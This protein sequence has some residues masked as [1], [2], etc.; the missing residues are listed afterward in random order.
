VDLKLTRQ[1]ETTLVY[2]KY[3]KTLNDYKISAG[4][5]GEFARILAEQGAQSGIFISTG[6]FSSDALELAASLSITLVGKEKLELLI[7]QVKRKNENLFN[8]ASW[9]GD[10]ASH[11]KIAD[12]QC[13]L[14]SKPMLLVV[15]RDGTPSW[16][17]SDQPA[18]LGKLDA[19]IDLMKYRRSAVS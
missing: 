13:P 11:A 14:C 17:C 19:R 18:C 4:E 16:Q 15:A 3:W 1:G 9:I 5:V 10:F 6:E 2:S 8:V 12:P 7:A